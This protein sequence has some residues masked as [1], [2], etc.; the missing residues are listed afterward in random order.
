M[1]DEEIDRVVEPEP[2]LDDLADRLR[3]AAARL[4]FE[5][6]ALGPVEDIAWP[7]LKR[8]EQDQ[9]RDLAFAARTV[10][11]CGPTRRAAS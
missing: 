10:M 9:W 6:L 1:S 5:R 4:R 8:S 11:A 7:M 3:I 2:G